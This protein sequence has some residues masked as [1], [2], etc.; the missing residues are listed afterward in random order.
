MAPPGEVDKVLDTIITNLEITNNVNVQPEMRARVM[1]TT[2]LESIYVGHTIVISRGL[3]D[4]LPDEATLAAVVAHEMGH[5]LLGHQLD[6]KYAFWDRLLFKDD[7]TLERVQL[8][9]SEREEDA[10]DE[11]AIELLKKSPYAAKLPKAG[12]FLKMLSARGDEMPHLIRPLLGNRMAA[13]SKD[14]RLSGLM[15][16]APPLELERIDQI[17]ALP[18]GAR[19]KMDP[20]ND[21]LSLMK[22]HNVPL[23]SA[24]EKLP[25]EI[26]PFMLHLTRESEDNGGAAPAGTNGTPPPSSENQPAGGGQPPAVDRSG[27][28]AASRR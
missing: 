27:Q 12:L 8:S 5:V 17:A 14:L 22:T 23:L 19:V 26:T 10:A 7:Q 21:H 2:P 25:F 13:N 11:K 16:Q 4:V 28:Q 3:L 1:L 15:D 24:R 9:R 20:W 6:T 18:L